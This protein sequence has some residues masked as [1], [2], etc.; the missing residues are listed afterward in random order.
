MNNL[1]SNYSELL[2]NLPEEMKNQKSW[3]NIRGKKKLPVQQD[4]KLLKWIVP[5]F[6]YTFKEAKQNSIINAP[7]M[8]VGFVVDDNNFLVLDLDSCFENDG[9]LK[10]WAKDITESINSFT[11]YS[12]S[13]N[14]LHIF[15]K[16]NKV[17]L[18]RNKI[19]LSDKKEAIELY[20]TKKIIT[21][22]GNIWNNRKNLETIDQ[23]TINKILEPYTQKTTDNKFTIKIKLVQSDQ[24]VIDKLQSNQMFQDLY[25][26]NITSLNNDISR[27]DYRLAF[28]ISTKTKDTLQIKRD[29][30]ESCG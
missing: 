12:Y 15:C 16:H 1:K 11:E 24:E 17:Q 21:V 6:R 27:A 18:K 2:E 7:F 3:V 9:Q 4:G 25:N 14:G 10:P 13:K 5:K 19:N 8:G 26:G 20:I 23:E 22:T 28:L 29:I 30:I